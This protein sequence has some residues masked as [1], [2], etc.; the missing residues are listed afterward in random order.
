MPRVYMRLIAAKIKTIDDV[1]EDMQAEV[2]ELLKNEKHMDGYG[3]PLADG[4]NK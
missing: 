4:E 1:R 2:L 3:N